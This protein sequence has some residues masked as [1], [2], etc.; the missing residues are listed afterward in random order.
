MKWI[1]LTGGIGCGKS[2]V[3]QKLLQRSI[4]VIDADQI[5]HQVVEKGSPGLKSIVNEFGQ[6][7][8]LPDGSLNRLKLGQFIFGDSD[9]KDK[10]ELILHPL[11]REETLKRRKVLESRNERIAVYDMPLLF[12]TNSQQ[13]FDKVIVVTCQV[14]QQLQR[15]RLRNPLWSEEEINKRIASQIPLSIKEQA[16]DFV[17]HNDGTKQHLDQEIKR[18]LQWLEDL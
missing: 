16:A 17:V 12:E 11:I 1:G 6:D 18:L 2:T 9:K 13:Q 8:L 15:L 5:A 10:V 7:L 3:T 14:Q 4:P